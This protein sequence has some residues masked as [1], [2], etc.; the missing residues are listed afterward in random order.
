MQKSR[1]RRSRCWGNEHQVH[2]VRGC[3]PARPLCRWMRRIRD[4]RKVCRCDAYHF[5]HRN[6]SG[7][8]GIGIPEVLRRCERQ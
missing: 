6:E 3:R 5:P 4:N 1:T 2:H 7:A 8:C